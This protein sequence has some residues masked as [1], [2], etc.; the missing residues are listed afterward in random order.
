[1]AEVGSYPNATT[2]TGT[3]RILA[4]Q[5]GKTVNIPLYLLL[6]SLA[7]PQVF[8]L[9]GQS[10]VT[11]ASNTVPAF[12]FVNGVLFYPGSDYTQSGNVLTFSA[13]AVTGGVLVAGLKSQ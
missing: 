12:V 1:M 13:G 11:L 7:N 9:S 2:L 10:T 4:D 5:N 3:E 6:A 8:S